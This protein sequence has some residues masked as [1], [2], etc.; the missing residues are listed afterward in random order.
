MKLGAALAPE[1]AV[2]EGADIF[3]HGHLP[4]AAAYCRTLGLVEL[5]DRL[6][7]T[8]MALRPG[9]AVQAMVLDTLAGRTPLYR[10]EQFLAAQDVEL[11]LGESVPS[12][13][14]TDT[15]LARSLDAIFAAGTAK[16]VTA[17]GVRA[18][19]TFGLDA[20]ALSYDTTPT[21]VWGEYRAGDD[22][23]EESPPGPAITFGHS[24]D[25][26]PDLKQFMTE[27]L[28][29]ERG[30]PI[31]GRT[32]DGNASDKTSNNQMLSR[33]GALMAQHG[34]GPGAFV[35]VA[36]SAM[37][38]EKNLAAVG[39][40][41]FLTRLPAT[42]NECA[43]VIAETVAADAWVP[44][45]SLAEHAADKGRPCAEYRACESAVTLYGTTYRTVVVHSSAHDK[46]RQKKLAKAVVDSATSITAAL[47]TVPDVYDCEA[48]AR[49]A[50]AR[51]EKLSDRLHTV[52]ATIRPVEVRRRGRPPLHRPAPTHTRY[53]LSRALAVNTAGVEKERSLAGC[54]VLLTNVPLKGDRGMDAVRVLQTYKGQYGVERDFAFLKDPLVVN[55]LFLKTPSRIDA[56][57]MI[58]IIALLVVRLME[59]SMRAHVANTN[60]TMPGWDRKQTTKPTAFMMII[61]MT[62]I[63]VARVGGARWLL[64][65]PGAT[66]LAFLH[67]LGLGPT[68][69]TDPHCRCVPIIPVRAVPKG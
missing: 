61:A 53:A 10:V 63:M 60:T 15:N 68:A 19:A 52:T 47:R 36:D 44:I 31:F 17:L 34:L 62:G 13:V 42:Y 23:S 24:K 8:G 37:V 27:L 66:P 58:L 11:L 12:P 38:T 56:L 51:A 30:V 40:N 16:I 20:S 45:G 4:A 69:F 39:P 1:F 26:R 22:D 35:Y 43:R 32:L 49:A 59:R 67:A 41:H 28:C 48:D 50:A 33:I 64:S 18:V 54:F 14:F 5:V 3:T 7:P 25:H 6:V 9:L 2:L 65:G 21:N 57:G 29:V 46:R 55:D